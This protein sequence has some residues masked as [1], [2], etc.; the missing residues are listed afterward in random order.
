[1]IRKGFKMKL[2]P[3]CEEEYERRHNLLWDEMKES[4]HKH[5]GRNYSIFL[6][7]ETLTLYGYIEIEDEELWAKQA[8]DAI[9]RKWWDFMADIM[10]TNPDNSPVSTE[11]HPVFHLD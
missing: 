10:E 5:G 1:M 6:D 9:N 8:D 7:R 3:G 2:Y 11:L 4:I